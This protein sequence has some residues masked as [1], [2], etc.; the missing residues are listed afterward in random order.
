[1][2]SNRGAH[3]LPPHVH[4][5]PLLVIG[6]G[7]E[8][9]GDDAVGRRVAEQVSAWQ[10]PSVLA[11]TAHQ[12]TPE[13][14]DALARAQVAV[15]VDA[16]VPDTNPGVCVRPIEPAAPKTVLEH[17]GDPRSLLALTQ[18]VFGHAPK[19]WLITVP[20]IRFD[21]GESLSDVAEQGA[22]EALEQIRSLVTRCTKSD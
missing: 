3:T 20:G 17:T 8:L 11:L 13:L 22:V 16:A 1:M 15:F 9:R 19:A 7:S 18:A 2:P 21:F 4:T 14:A 12:L 6:Y 5:T 10:S